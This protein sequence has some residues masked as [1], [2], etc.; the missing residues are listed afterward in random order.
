MS[1]RQRLDEDE[2]SEILDAAARVVGRR[3]L[4]DTRLRDIADE[5][6]SSV[7]TLQHYFG[8]RQELLGATFRHTQQRAV[9]RYTEQV[10]GEQ[11]PWLKI[12]AFIDDAVREP[13]AEEWL[14][15]L[16]FQPTAATDTEL[17]EESNETFG[18]WKGVLIEII[19]SGRSS[20][21]FEPVFETEG[22][23]EMMLALVDGLG[24]HVLVGRSTRDRMRELLMEG[25]SG[26]LGVELS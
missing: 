1:P 9:A 22:T 20:G 11:D 6:G 16:M 26:L 17:R 2:L 15:W 4:A 12:V 18:I 14:P 3:T 21:T 23:V 8:S 10:E 24:V 7:G 25:Y 19:E 13:F 5:A